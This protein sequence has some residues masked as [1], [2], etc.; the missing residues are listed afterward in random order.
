MLE[1]TAYCSLYSVYFKERKTEYSQINLAVS[2]ISFIT[3]R[4]LTM[5]IITRITRKSS[6]SYI[7]IS[8]YYS[9]KKQR[10]VM[11][12]RLLGVWSFS[13][14]LYIYITNLP[15][16]GVSIILNLVTRWRHQ[17]LKQKYLLSSDIVP[18]KLASNPSLILIVMCW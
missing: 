18:I 10:K 3:P 8:Q 16:L 13:L 12:R 2:N 5:T 4:L 7:Y 17:Y 1:N 9:T 14:S 6:V 15:L 11:T